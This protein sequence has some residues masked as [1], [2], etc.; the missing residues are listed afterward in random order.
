MTAAM[1]FSIAASILILAI[2]LATGVFYQKRLAA[3][4]TDHLQLLGQAEKLGI[5]T[6][7]TGSASDSRL[8][9]RQHGDR[10]SE[11]HS[12][13]AD[14]AAFAREM[15]LHEKGSSGT[16]ESIQKRG[17]EIMARLMEL[18]ASQIKVVIAGLRDDKSLSEETRMNMLGITLSMLGEDHP[19][20]ALALFTEPPGLLVGSPLAKHVVATSLSHWAN[21]DPLA[22][23]AWV[24][25]NSGD[26]PDL[27]DDETK[28]S[29]LAGAART[30]PKL[31]FKLIDEMHFGDK[32]AAAQSLVEAG[33][34][35]A[36]RTAIL[37]ALREHLATIP[38]DADRQDLFKESLES[39]GRGLSEESF[40]SVQAWISES[41]LSSQESAQFAAG[42]SYFNTKQDTGR[43]IDWMARNLPEEQLRENVD[44]LIGQW[45]QQ[46]YQAAGKWLAAAPDGPAKSAS[47]NTYAGTVAEYDPGTAIQ[48]ALTLPEGPERQTTLEKIYQNWPKNDAASAAAFAKEHGITTPAEP[49][50]ER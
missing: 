17:M 9:K 12:L 19:A 49:K 10:V 33:K 6:R 34:T 28:Q 42:L 13:A 47:I 32:S 46:D 50:E 25:R 45:T 8:T 2:G 26:H 18:D 30:D 7:L 41:K 24:R 20:A 39:M 22:A 27:A 11:A 31:A 38:D 4:R 48:W 15:E 40:D 43:W 44:N 14:L 16:D 23:L 1:K 5:S 37:E 21:Q 36:Q 35:P 29:V 3:L